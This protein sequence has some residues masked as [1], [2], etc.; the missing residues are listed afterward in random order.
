MESV[1]SDF[2]ILIRAIVILGVLILILLVTDQ[3]Q[4]LRSISFKSYVFSGLS[5][6]ATSAS[7][8]CYFRALKL[9]DASRL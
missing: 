8:V 4:P 3:F 9:G 1:N 5:G 2:A 7:W 6:I